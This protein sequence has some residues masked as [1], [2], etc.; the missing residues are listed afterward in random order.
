MALVRCFNLSSWRCRGRSDRAFLTRDT[1]TLRASTPLT[2][3]MSLLLS[4]TIRA[5][6]S[7]KA[8][9]MGSKAQPGNDDDITPLDCIFACSVCGDVFSDVYQQ[10]DT[11][12][13]LSDGINSKDRIVTR[14]YVASCCHVICIKH[15]EGGSGEFSRSALFRA[16][17]D[18]HGFRASFS[19]SW[20]AP[21]STL[22]SMCEGKG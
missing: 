19:S 5:K 14:L 18:D 1:S 9:V 7:L 6:K 2:P 10:P 11:V 3:T 16:S 17:V 4:T 12:H 15:I 13:G 20:A 8:F 22:S 21:R